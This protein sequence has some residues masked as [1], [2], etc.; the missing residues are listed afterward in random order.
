MCP[1]C[2]REL[3]TTVTTSPAAVWSAWPWTLASTEKERAFAP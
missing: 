3:L 2:V 1:F